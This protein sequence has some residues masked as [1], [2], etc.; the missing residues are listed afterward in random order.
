VSESLSYLLPIIATCV[1]VGVLCLVMVAYH[2]WREW[3]HPASWKSRY[4]T[5]P[6]RGK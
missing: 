4:G 6:G 1:A 3:P 2:T 5:V